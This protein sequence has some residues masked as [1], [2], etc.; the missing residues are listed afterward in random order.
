MLVID[1]NTIE[2]PEPR[3]FVLGEGREYRSFC[4]LRSVPDEAGSSREHRSKIMEGHVLR[5]FSYD[6]KAELGFFELFRN[7]DRLAG[8]FHCIRSRLLKISF[9]QAGKEGELRIQRKNPCTALRDSEDFQK[10]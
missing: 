6:V 9:L 10:N 2:E 4:D 1:S 7:S 3:G 5:S 8:T